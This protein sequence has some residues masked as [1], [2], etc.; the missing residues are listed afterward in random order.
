VLDGFIG[1]SKKLDWIRLYLS[2]SFDTFVDIPVGG[3]IS[4]QP[5]DAT[6]ENSPTRVW[7]RSETTLDVVQRVSQTMEASY[8][9]G[10]IAREHL[11]SATPAGRSMARD[12]SAN[13]GGGPGYT[14]GRSLC[15]TCEPPASGSPWLCP[16]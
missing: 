16:K 9:R 7:I 6:N 13:A 15:L 10:G 3:I 8:L 14:F 11:K 5:V 4:T 2:L 1:P 12:I